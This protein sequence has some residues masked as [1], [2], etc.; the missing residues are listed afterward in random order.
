M[1]NSKSVAVIGSGIAGLATAVRLA[2][3]G[4][5]VDVFEKN[6]YPGGKLSHFSL[7]GYNFDAGPSLFT[8]PENI[9]DLFELCEE[10]VS[11]YFTFTPVEVAFKYFF[12]SGKVINAFVGAEK[13]AK[14]L[15]EKT[16]EPAE[17]VLTYLANAGKAYDQIGTLFLNH[18]LHKPS[19]YFQKGVV[20]AIKATRWPYLVQSMNTYNQHH[21]ETPEA[22]QIFNRFATYNGS[23]PYTAPAMLTMIP[24]LEQSQ[25]T[26][27]PEGGMISITNAVYKLALKMGV[28]FHFNT[29]VTA[30]R[31][32]GGVVTGVT[33]DGKD[34]PFAK[35]VSNMDVY[36]TYLKLLQNQELAHKV[37][38]Q[39]RSSSAIIFYWGMQRVFP[40]L[41]L[42]NIFFTKNYPEEFR[43][44]FTHK[45]L[46]DDP[47]VY[48]NITSKLEMTHAPEGCENW[49]VM[50]NAPHDTG[51][52]WD[53][54]RAE[55]RKR[56]LSKMSRMLDADLESYIVAE[57]YLDP[58]EIDKRTSSYTG[59][60][61]GTSSNS[62]FAAF[63][64]HKNF[65][66]T[67]KG[68]YFVGGSVH[69][70]G[71]IPL[72]LKSAMITSE[73]IGA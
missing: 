30:I 26:F 21:F 48:I 54:F 62:R 41:H 49:F 73:M 19:T 20:N 8:Q 39:E 23:N 42:H 72:C 46:F 10:D 5:H 15:Q 38:K 50:I 70:G 63:L 55:A 44:I 52:P 28:N 17:N 35:V 51:Q 71:G 69:P 68:L 18:S 37:T 24:H 56:I 59:S 32:L 67:Y 66:D 60:L 58:Y 34:I 12:E 65:S 45:T 64:R 29:E 57:D 27:Y 4:Y 40:E 31:T 3:K 7:D 61:Y 16:G 43:H 6:A 47:T 36:Y 14:E 13:F 33:M 25:G 11:D 2:Q 53:E 1:T 22:V 9:V